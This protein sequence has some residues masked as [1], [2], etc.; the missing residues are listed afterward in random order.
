MKYI[1]AYITGSLFILVGLAIA[2]YG[3]IQVW[4]AWKSN[5][6]VAIEG[7]IIESTVKSQRDS[8]G[9][10]YSPAVRYSFRIGG[11]DYVGTR[12]FFGDRYSE[13]DT[14]YANKYVAQYPAGS[15]VT[16]YYNPTEPSS[17]VLQRGA[18]KK[19]YLFLAFGIG[20]ASF[21]AWFCFMAWMC[22]D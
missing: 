2:L 13:R 22:E 9:R 4:N 14:A 12:V 7:E 19:T 16:V 15:K 1:M 10:N 3:L 17:A 11:H 8:D 21:A 18:F 20:F 6:W 5:S